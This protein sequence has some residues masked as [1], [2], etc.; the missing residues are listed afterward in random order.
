MRVR[1][2]AYSF[3]ERESR[4]AAVPRQPAHFKTHPGRGTGGNHSQEFRII[5]KSK[6]CVNINDAGS[7]RDNPVQVSRHMHV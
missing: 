7:E 2:I 5:F 3:H 1:E 6:S 4:Y